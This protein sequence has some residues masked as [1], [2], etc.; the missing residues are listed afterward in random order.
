[1]SCLQSIVRFLLLF[2]LCFVSYTG[3]G[4]CA[5]ERYD[6]VYIWDT[7]LDNVLDYKDRLEEI[8]DEK[9]SKRLK[10]V[11]KGN[12]YGIIYDTNGNVT[13]IIHDFTSHGEILRK[14]GL[15]EAWAVKDEGYHELYNVSYGLGPNVDELKKT[16]KK[17]YQ[18]LGKDVGK[19]LFIEKTDSNNY[20][21][22][23]R[24]R[25]DQ[26]STTR[27]A[28][29]H[30]K[31]LRKIKVRTSITRENNNEVVYGESSLLNDTKNTDETSDVKNRPP[32]V[33]KEPPKK[34]TK[35]DNKTG[36]TIAAAN[37]VE[38]D[39]ERLIKSLRKK[40]HIRGDERTGWM[41]Y[42]LQN[43]K[44]VVDINANI[45]FQAAS[46]IKPFVALAFFHKVKHGTLIYG[47]KSRRMME[48]MIQRSSNSATNWVMKQA[49]GPA[50]C[51][52]LLRTHYPQIFKNV[53]INEY[54][55]ASGRTY[56]N[57]AIPADYIR[58]LKALW[59]NKLP[60]G[61]ELRRVMAL[62]GRDRLYHGTPIPQGTLIY[63][64]TG[65]T[66]H[67]IGD[68]GILVPKTRNG[69]RHPYAIVGIIER[70]SR[71][72]NYSRWMLTRSNV[73][74][75]VS[76]LVYKDMKKKYRLL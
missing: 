37:E 63:N 27:V 26:R 64:K 12:E 46:M 33:A 66:A 6:L 41:V 31:M 75:Q 7:N 48:A 34:K 49:G 47:P 30:A 15:D 60:Y 73:I 59:N 32:V 9:V 40:G 35:Q 39:V 8:F 25:G 70:S 45:L 4:L 43:D 62:P 29:Q 68:M 10:I 57:S 18:H 54:I 24:R 56:K 51:Q 11:G 44:P 74:R 52:K 22:I 38:R 20:T 76:T 19:N 53:V 42:D 61:K 65:S 58:F 36:L 17:I 14:A 71:P 28:R 3:I 67:L 2:I 72:S 55:P 23:Y 21:L 1:M 50:S 16:Y 69:K 5:V 13:N